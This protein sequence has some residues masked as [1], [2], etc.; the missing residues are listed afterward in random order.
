MNK[1]KVSELPRKEKNAHN[2]IRIP[3]WVFGGLWSFSGLISALVLLMFLVIA[4][5]EPMAF[6]EDV[7]FFHTVI[8]IISWGTF[9]SLGLGVIYLV[10]GF[11]YRKL[12]ANGKTIVIGIAL[13]TILASVL[14]MFSVWDF[15]AEISKI[16]AHDIGDEVEFMFFERFYDFAM[17][18]GILVSIVYYL[19]PAILAYIGF[20]RLE[21]IQSE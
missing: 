7:D 16:A 17:I 21:K 10:L 11:T 14:L 3:A 2:M 18:I 12:I 1:I 5:N 4:R 13:L 15:T 8:G 6:S 20:H 9:L 19:I